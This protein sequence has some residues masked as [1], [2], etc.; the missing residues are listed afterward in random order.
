MSSSPCADARRFT[1][2]GDTWIEAASEMW[3]WSVSLP[4]YSGHT[5]YADSSQIRDCA[6]VEARLHAF[7]PSAC[8]RGEWLS[9]RSGRLCLQKGAAGTRC[10]GI[11]MGPRLVAFTPVLKIKFALSLLGIDTWTQLVRSASLDWLR[12]ENLV[13]SL[14]SDLNP[15]TIYVWART[16]SID[17][18]LI[19]QTFKIS[20]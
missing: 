11:H 16:W 3:N 2:V 10:T 19:I 18:Q 9:S 7:L 6:A 20:R 14:W 5:R 4:F 15:S 17:C 12:Q 1:Y 8:W 13:K